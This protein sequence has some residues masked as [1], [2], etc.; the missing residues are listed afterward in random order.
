M[1][2]QKRTQNG[3]THKPEGQWNKLADVMVEIFKESAHPIFLGIS[4]L[5]RGILKSEGGRCTIHFSAES[6]KTELLFRTIH[7]ANQPSSHGAV[8]I[9]VKNRLK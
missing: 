8:A 5:N 9:C 7:S 3:D 2:I 4:A 1:I 6:S